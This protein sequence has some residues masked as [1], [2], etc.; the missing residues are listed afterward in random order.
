MICLDNTDT[1]EAGASVDAVVDYTVQGLVGGVFT[2]IAQGQLSNTDPTL[3]YTAAAAISIV[4]V[5][6]VNTHAAAVAV[7]LY[8]DPANAGTPRRMIPEDLSLGISYSLHFDGARC[9]VMNA[10]GQLIQGCG[11]HA[12]NHTN[13]T[14]D[15]QDAT[16]AQKGVATA[17]QITKL[18]G[19]TALA[20]VTADNAPQAHKDSH[21]PNDGG[22]PLDTAAAG[23]IVGVAAAAEGTA[24]SLARSDHTHQVQHS[25]ADNHIIT[26]DG[27]C[28]DNDYAK[29]TADGLEGRTVT[30][31]RT[32]IG[33]PEF[34]DIYIDSSAMYHRETL[35]CGSSEQFEHVTNGINLDFLVFPGD[36]D[37][38]AQ[39]KV[40]M[41]E[42]W[43]LS[44]VKFFFYWGSDE[45]D[46]GDT[47][48]MTLAGASYSDSFLIDSA[49][50][51]DVAVTDTVL[52]ADDDMQISAASAVITIAN[53]PALHDMILFEVMRDVSEDDMAEDA[54]LYG[55]F[56]Q[57]GV[58]AAVT[59][60]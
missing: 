46:N 51:D 21:D 34:R 33:M 45:G 36:A 38:F 20:D 35:P 60:L 4:S 43:D 56:I 22:D 29:F 18:D 1:L 48:C 40:V 3:I 27:T 30:E 9:S 8:L 19:I 55:I 24:H 37:S 6:F 17:A 44:T 58:L 5:T 32:D 53:T 2:N 26:A 28:A 41:P 59:G 16:A 14:D 49:M 11:A 13:G 23:E 31:L 54:R 50:G 39:F 10:S 57:Y 12:T 42:D 25:I 47:C 15:I 52:N 7:N